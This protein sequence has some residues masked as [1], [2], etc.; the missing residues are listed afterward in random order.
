MS[1]VSAASLPLSRPPALR[2]ARLALDLGE[3][4]FARQLILDW[5]ARYPGDLQAQA[6]RAQVYLAAGRLRQAWT[7]LSQITRKDPQDAAIQALL[8]ETLSGLSQPGALSAGQ[9]ANGCLL[10]LGGSPHPA[11]PVPPWGESLRQARQSLAGGDAETALQQVQ[12]ILGEP[13]ATPLIAVTHLQAL[14]LGLQD[15]EE[16][17]AQALLH[18]GGHYRQAWPECL[19]I[20]LALAEALLDGPAP[21]LGVALLHQAAAEDVAGQVAGRRWG[22]ENPYRALWPETLEI[23]AELHLPPRLLAALGS[24]RPLA[25][26]QPP[27]A[28][29][30]AAAPPEAQP[31]PEPAR[32]PALPEDEPAPPQE[33]LLAARPELERID[34]R[35]NETALRRSPGRSAV[36]LAL[37]SRRGLTAQYGVQGFAAV[38]LALKALVAAVDA[39][40]GWRAALVYFDDPVSA[41]AYGLRPLLRSD[42]WAIKLALADFDEALRKRGERIGALLIAGGPQIVPFHHLPNPIDDADPDVPSD[43]PYGARDENYF[44]PEWPVGRIPGDASDDPRPLVEALRRAARQHHNPQPAPGRWARWQRQALRWLQMDGKA[45]LPSLGY[46]AA[47][48]RRAAQQVFEPIGAPEAMWVS[49]PSDARAFAGRKPQAA[50]LAYFNLHGVSDSEEWYGHNDPGRP[51]PGPDYPVA[52][53]PA[54]I[55]NH[56]SAPQMVFSEACYGAHILGKTVGSSLALKFLSAGAEAVVGSTCTAYG[57][58]ASPLIAADLL[59]QAY[60]TRLSQDLSAGEALRQAKLQLIQE[61]ER[62]QGFLDGEDQKTLI[63]FVLYG[64]PL[65]HPLAARRRQPKQA[66]VSQAL[67]EVHTVCDRADPDE[68]VAVAGETLETVKR[69]VRQYLPGMLDAAVSVSQEHAACTG[70]DHLCPTAQLAPKNLPDGESAA[71]S[72]GRKVVILSKQVESDGALHRHYARLTLNKQE[73]VVKLV[74]SR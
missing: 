23:T 52:L 7:L 35:K 16:V 56:G 51:Y 74:V 9:T 69:V 17:R 10:A 8:A 39:L 44:V 58:I 6:L 12:P 50:R 70:G 48:W 60:W 57:S 33:S 63:S 28:P 40:P 54:D 62:R 27:Q 13:V 67:P 49:P 53:R 1:A 14:E 37:S 3:L 65:A 32:A 30:P 20:S 66:P 72:G 73:Q 47:I 59:G 71:R 42:P 19:P 18:L 5:L 55:T 36:Y 2:L 61:M 45:A 64:D 4:S 68:P 41:A 31:A 25:R 11:F 29:A 38:D 22:K 26:Q 21:E 24:S 15:C 43:N 34:A 46:T